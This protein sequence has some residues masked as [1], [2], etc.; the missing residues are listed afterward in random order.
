WNTDIGSGTDITANTL[1]LSASEVNAFAGL[2]TGVLKIGSSAVT[3]NVKVSASL[4]PSFA[5]ALALEAGGNITQTA[6]IIF[7]SLSAVATQTVTL[8]NAGN[9][10]SNLAGSAALNDA[11]S[12]FAF[13]FKNAGSF[14]V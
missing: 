7:P 14:G 2:S 11:T 4:A 12:G 5:G 1:E 3:G 10:V 6:P 9:S 13:S 8:T